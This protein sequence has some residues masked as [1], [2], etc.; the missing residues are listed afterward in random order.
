[1][2]Y[3]GDGHDGIWNIITQITSEHRRREV[4]DWYHLMENLYKVDASPSDLKQ[5]KAFLWSGCFEGAWKQL[6]SI[7]TYASQTFRAYLNKHRHRIVPYDF[8][9]IYTS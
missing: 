7:D 8:P 6:K 2:T 5:I 4:L 9:M 3:V 1:V